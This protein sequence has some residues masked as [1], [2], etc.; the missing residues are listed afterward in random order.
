MN[1]GWTTLLLL[2]LVYAVLVTVWNLLLM[3]LLDIAKR[4]VRRLATDQT[5]VLQAEQ[6]VEHSHLRVPA[7][8]RSLR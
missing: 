5:P 2:A 6:I 3:R 1:A 4:D 7:R 8:R